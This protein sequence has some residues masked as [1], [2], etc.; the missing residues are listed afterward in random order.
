MFYSLDAVT[1]VCV[2]ACL[3]LVCI[4]ICTG[5]CLPRIFVRCVDCG[6]T[7]HAPRVAS[8]FPLRI[9][10]ICFLIAGVCVEALVSAAAA[11]GPPPHHGQALLSEGVRR[12]YVPPANAAAAQGGL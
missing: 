2:C 5:F 11:Q 8:S 10:N 12:R 7:L 3:F 9:H 1:H 4:H 6:E